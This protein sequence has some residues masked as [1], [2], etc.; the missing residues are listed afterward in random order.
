MKRAWKAPTKAHFAIADLVHDGYV[1]V[2]LTTNFDRLLENALRDRGVEPTVV[3]TVDALMGAEPLAHSACHLVKLHGDYKDARIFN[4]EAELAKY[5]PEFNAHLDR[6][7]DDHGLV[8]CGWSGKW[9]VALNDAILRSPSRR[10]SLYWAARGNLGDQGK[11]I[12]VQRDGHIVPIVDA[13]DFFET[14]R[15]RIQLIARTRAQDP[16]STELLVQSTKRAISSPERVI[17]LHDLLGSELRR[18]EQLLEDS[19]PQDALAAGGVKRICDF[20]ETVSEPLGRMFGIVGRWGTDQEGDLAANA[21]LT[22]W[23]EESGHDSRRAFLQRY[24]AVLVLWSY[25][26]GLTLAKRWP[27]LYRLLFHPVSGDQDKSRALVELLYDW[28]AYSYR[29]QIF[30]RLP[31]EGEYYT[32]AADHLFAV[33]GNWG[34]SFAPV[35]PDFEENHDVWEIIFGIAYW[36]ARCDRDPVDFERWQE[37]PVGRMAR[38]ASSRERILERI[39]S[40]D[41]GNDLISAG[42]FGKDKNKLTTIVNGYSR[43]LLATE[44]VSKKS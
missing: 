30:S 13:D 16:W 23:K 5:P 19:A 11:R 25:G 37:A 36:E 27:A 12:V 29:D 35:S 3:D 42:F 15:D 10:Y 40:G 34:D 43:L 32:T 21:L 31:R 24:P 8:V 39:R 28:C 17:E 41:L 14:L 26:I 7:F 6:I 22:V 38:R 4:T 33:L 9:D 20:Y 44:M 1:R 18:L 2:I